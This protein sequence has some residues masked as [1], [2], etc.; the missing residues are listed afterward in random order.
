M[1]VANRLAIAPQ[2]ADKARLAT[3][4]EYGEALR[5]AVVRYLRQVEEALKA[6][7]RS[8]GAAESDDG[9]TNQ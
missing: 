2:G 5:S 4:A 7:E 3:N 9:V 8:S 6:R 1:L